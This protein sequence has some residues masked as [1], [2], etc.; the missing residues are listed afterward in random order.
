MSLKDYPEAIRRRGGC[1]VSWLYYADKATAEKAAKI[2]EHNARILE[3]RGYDFG[4]CCPGTIRQIPDSA[5]PYEV[6][7]P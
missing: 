4:Y 2:A 6:C 7:I 5:A 1:K 3:G